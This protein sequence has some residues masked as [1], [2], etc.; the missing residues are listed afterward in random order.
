MKPSYSRRQFVRTSGI[1]AIG[2][3][4]VSNMPLWGHTL[5]TKEEGAVINKDPENKLPFV[6]VRA[7]S[8]WCNIEDLLWSQKSIVDKIKYRA[9]A[10]A[11]AGIDTAINF[12]FHIRFDFSNYFGQLHGYYANVCEELHKYDIKFMDHYSCNHV[13]RPRGEEEFRK[14][15]KEQ[16]HHVL[17]FHDPVA[18]EYAQ[19]EGHYFKDLCEVDFRDGS[20]GYARQYQLEVFCHNNPGFL[21]MHGKYLRRLMH[22]VPFDGIEV[23]DM[24][25]YAG[26][27]TCGCIYCRDRFKRDFGHEIPVFG[28]PSFWGDTT[29]NMF[30]WGNYENPI[31]RDWI[32][33]KAD[34]VADHLK[35]VKSIIGEKPLMTC[36]S[37]SGPVS[38]NVIALNLERMSPFLDFFMLENCGIDIS[39]VDWVRMDAEAMHQKD[40]AQKRGNAPALALS[41][42]I[43][44]KGGYLGWCLSRFWGVANWSSTLTQRLEEDPENAME[45]ETIIGPVNDWEIHHSNLNYRH[46]RDLVE[47]RLVNSRFC[48][49]NGWRGDDGLEQWDR[50][51]K[52]T[53]NLIK[54]NTGYRFVRCEELSDPVALCKEKT[55]LIMDGIGCVSDSQF[56]A[57]KTYLSQGGT[58]WLALPFGTHDDKGVRRSVPL[59]V[60]LLKRGFKNLVLTDSASISDPM[61]KLIGQGRFHP[62]LTQLSGDKRWAARIRFYNYQPVIHFMN[63]AMLAVP[64]PL[65][66]DTGGTP[67]I[68]DIESA[69][70]NNR[71][72][73]KID[74]RR[75]PVSEL[76]VVSPELGGEI[77]NTQIIYRK[78]GFA[79][80]NINL[81]GVKVYATVQNPKQT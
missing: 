2:L 9:E 47:V 42:T 19:Y 79:E 55:P 7:A 30:Q 62:A 74:T 34:S 14:L 40:I 10:F 3:G 70:V 60:E 61:E 51:T 33:M 24:C 36:C 57:V 56:N 66:K 15:H 80:I 26:L 16:R 64:H 71:L 23:D 32:N 5:F 20:R 38:L 63:T 6:P 25:D 72:S 48:R 65:I 68:K 35:M 76:A 52:W 4:V 41:Y 27:T 59:S 75:I 12:G 78:K 39:S 58:A 22:E 77:R 43:Y 53:L 81:D 73:Y 54:N 45:I 67:V 13:E 11:N 44:E 37:S 28:D 46:G 29:K 18:A 49:E 17:L 31:F 8:W 69:I 21:E 50:V 1:N